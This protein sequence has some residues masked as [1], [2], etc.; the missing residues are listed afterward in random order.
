MDGTVNLLKLTP[1]ADVQ[2][3]ELLSK[4]DNDSTLSEPQ[5]CQLVS[6]VTAF[7][8]TCSGP[9]TIGKN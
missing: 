3:E 2:V 1:V 8:D 9:I 5:K 7:S 4:L 6:V